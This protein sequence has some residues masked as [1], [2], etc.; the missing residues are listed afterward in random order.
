MSQ[1]SAT[2]N[3]HFDTGIVATDARA[4]T[5]GSVSRRVR[6]L[7]RRLAPTLV[8]IGALVLI[9]LLAR[10]MVDQARQTAA[11]LHD[12]GRR[13]LVQLEDPATWNLPVP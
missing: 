6:A 13:W 1:P 2:S 3:L 11:E 7:T 8:S 9:V 12:E 4:T 5:T 10:D